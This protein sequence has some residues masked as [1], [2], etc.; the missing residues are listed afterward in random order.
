M[1]TEAWVGSWAASWAWVSVWGWEWL[2]TGERV[3]VW[4]AVWQQTRLGL[5]REPLSQPHP[6]D[7]FHWKTENLS[8][9]WMTLSGLSAKAEGARLRLRH[10]GRQMHHRYLPEKERGDWR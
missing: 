6:Q 8:T 9:R 5:R 2:L 4:R 3:V 1:K 7:C 10:C